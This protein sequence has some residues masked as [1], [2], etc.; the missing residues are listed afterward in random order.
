M[1]IPMMFQAMD[2]TFMPDSTVYIMAAPRE[3]DGYISVRFGGTQNDLRYLLQEIGTCLYQ[4]G[5]ISKE[6][7]QANCEEEQGLEH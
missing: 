1:T 5:V 2:E 3:E 4:A 6:Q 7:W